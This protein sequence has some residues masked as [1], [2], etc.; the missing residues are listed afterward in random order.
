MAN[1]R[2]PLAPPIAG[3]TEDDSK[4]GL[5]RNAYKEVG[6][7]GRIYTVKR[8]GLESAFAHDS[9]GQGVHQTENTTYSIAGNTLREET[10]AFWSWGIANFL[11]DGTTTTRLPYTP[12]EQQPVFT[13]FYTGFPGLSSMHTL[14]ADG[15]MWSW[16]I[17][18]YSFGVPITVVPP[19]TLAT[20]PVQ[21]TLVPGA[22]TR[23]WGSAGIMTFGLMADGTLWAC[24]VNPTAF[25]TLENPLGIGPQEV[26]VAAFTQVITAGGS[27]DSDWAWCCPTNLTTFAIKTTGTLWW[28][29]DNGYGTPIGTTMTQL[30]SDSDWELVVAAPITYALALKTDGTIHLADLSTGAIPPVF[31]QF[32]SDSDWSDVGM[33][34]IQIIGTDP[35]FSFFALKDDGSLYAWGDNRY[36]QLGDG[37]TTDRASPVQVRIPTAVVKIARFGVVGPSWAIDEDGYV[38]MWGCGYDE[39][40]PAGYVLA[41][42]Y[43]TNPYPVRLPI[44]A[45]VVDFFVGAA[46]LGLAAKVPKTYELVTDDEEYQFLSNPPAAGQAGF[47]LK[48]RYKLYYFE[49]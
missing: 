34:Y 21:A 11:G 43:R 19:D 36:G 31:A 35:A 18:G 22:F 25:P 29:G 30:G 37:T 24:G 3:R 44:G 17:N 41:G 13:S 40:Q 38:W 49:E 7:K 10:D 9:L 8:S 33:H 32:G 45:A 42:G 1:V 16:G 5:C 20:E 14:K 2:L 47:L 15:S 26:P 39:V 6:K 46:A 48:S 12:A 27:L 23:L 4:D 28:C